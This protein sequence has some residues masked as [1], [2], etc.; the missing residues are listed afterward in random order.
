[1][2]INTNHVQYVHLKDDLIKI[3]LLHGDYATF[4]DDSKR[5]LADVYK[6]LTHDVRTKQWIELD[7]Y[8]S[9]ED[10]EVTKTFYD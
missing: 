9:T 1:M 4:V 7:D 8:E 5:S 10:K 2:L 3:G 6:D